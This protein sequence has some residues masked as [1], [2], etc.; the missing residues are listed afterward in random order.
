M[1]LQIS[2]QMRVHFGS[3]RRRA[4]A[5]STNREKPAN[6]ISIPLTLPPRLHYLPPLMQIVQGKCCVIQPLSRNRKAGKPP[7]CQNQTVSA[8][9]TERHP[10]KKQ[11]ALVAFLAI[12]TSHA[13]AD[14]A[15]FDDKD[16]GPNH[17]YMPSTHGITTW[18][19]A[20]AEFS[21]NYNTNYSSWDGITYSDVN[22]TTTSGIGNQYAAYGGDGLDRSDGGVYAV[23]YYASW[24]PHTT[25]SFASAMTVNG[26]YANNTTYAALDMLNGSGFSK[27][28]GG[29]SGNDADWFKMTIEGFDASSASQGSVDF[30]LADYRF[31][32]NGL[33]YIID[34][35][36]F[37]D[38]SGLGSNVSSIQ[39]S[40]SSSDNGTWGMNTPAYFAIDE[41]EAVPEPA[42]ALLIMLG[43]FGIM[44]FRRYKASI[45]A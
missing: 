10:M 22:D 23:G 32:D 5:S 27:K 1:L 15:T 45:G 24:D 13:V 18:N 38:L 6:S 14:V 20:N 12:L 40:L 7:F 4:T 25:I 33:D 36:T 9:E 30:Y 21:V 28:F 35:W 17:Y 31:A 42:S 41:L 34:D 19:D 26:F 29:D 2:E 43:S 16:T 44:G 11:A 3:S 8:R 39:F 37:V